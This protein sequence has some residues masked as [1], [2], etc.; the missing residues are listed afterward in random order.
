MR[1]LFCIFFLIAMHKCFS[2]GMPFYAG[3]YVKMNA[4]GLNITSTSEPLRAP[5]KS[6][7]LWSAG[8]GM[9]FVSPEWKK[10]RFETQLGYESIGSGKEYYYNSGSNEWARIYDR[11]RT[12]PIALMIRRAIT[13]KG[14]WYLNAGVR[15]ALVIDHDVKHDQT[16]PG[17]PGSIIVS[18][19]VKTTFSSAIAEIGWVRPHGD[20]VISGW[21]SRFPLIEDKNVRVRPFGIALTIK[22]AVF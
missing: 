7:M 8:A 17:P 13:K 10:F 9:F 20:I 6:T 3:L 14:V 2:Q 15:L 11:Y 22:A 1:K 5:E 4:S 18:P 12:V 19:D 21:Y 16:F